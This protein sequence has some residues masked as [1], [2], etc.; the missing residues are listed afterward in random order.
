MDNQLVT[1]KDL[2][3]IDSEEINHQLEKI[4]EIF[5]SEHSINDY[6]VFEN[7]Y[8]ILDEVATFDTEPFTTPLSDRPLVLAS[9]RSDFEGHPHMGEGIVLSLHLDICTDITADVERGGEILRRGGW[10]SGEV[11]LKHVLDGVAAILSGAADKVLGAFVRA[12]AA[13]PA[14]ETIRLYDAAQGVGGVREYAE[15]P[16]VDNF[17]DD[18]YLALDKLPDEKLGEAL[19]V[20]E[21]SP[22]GKRIAGSINETIDEKIAYMLVEDLEV[23]VGKAQHAAIMVALGEDVDL[24]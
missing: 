6:L 4:N 10:E 14:G 5:P 22:F 1:A 21:A 9:F 12:G 17:T 20:V 24:S 23:E 15:F 11:T 18:H 2:S 16:A 19:K 3:G 13:S 8:N 7:I